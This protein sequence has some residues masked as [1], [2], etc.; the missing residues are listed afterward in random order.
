ML[1]IR[2]RALLEGG[3]VMSTATTERQQ[4]V[5]S[6]HVNTSPFSQHIVAA[7]SATTHTAGPLSNPLDPVAQ[8]PSKSGGMLGNMFK[9]GF[10]ARPVVRTEE[11]NY[12]YMMALDR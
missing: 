7:S 5:Q 2:P 1:S 12:R 4:M 3:L 6:T 10:F 9:S 11:E 8:P